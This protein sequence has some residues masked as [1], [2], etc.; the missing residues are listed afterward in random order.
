MCVRTFD[1]VHWCSR[2][3]ACART[4]QCLGRLLQMTRTSFS[5][6]TSR[7]DRER[8][9]WWHRACPRPTTSRSTCRCDRSGRIQTSHQDGV[10]VPNE[11]PAIRWRT[12]PTPPASTASSPNRITRRSAT[13]TSATPATASRTGSRPACRPPPARLEP[14]SPSN[15]IHE[16]RHK[17]P[18][19][20]PHQR[21]VMAVHWCPRHR[22][23]EMNPVT[24]TS[25]HRP[26]LHRHPRSAVDSPTSPAR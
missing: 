21:G 5:A 26:P 12:S 7:L 24:P 8:R 9:R 14:P 4:H 22:L 23:W 18:H 2:K 25:P 1:A 11:A 6:T 15:R 10:M 13:P 20:P 17:R 3:S 19:P 16:D